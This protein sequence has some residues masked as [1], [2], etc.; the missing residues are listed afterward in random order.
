MNSL[1]FLSVT[2]YLSPLSPFINPSIT[3]GAG[4][5]N[6]RWLSGG[7]SK[8]CRLHTFS[9]RAPASAGIASPAGF[10][11]LGKENAGSGARRR[12]RAAA[13]FAA[14][15][16]AEGASHLPRAGGRGSRTAPG[17]TWAGRCG[18]APGRRKREAR[19][20]HEVCGSRARARAATCAGR[21]GLR[22]GAL[23]GA[24]RRR[25]CAFESANSVARQPA[26]R[27]GPARRNHPWRNCGSEPRADN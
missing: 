18:G 10:G 24:R 2:L 3:K 13:P 12:T 19:R 25:R 21:A 7:D 26:R 27:L 11:G 23:L 8:G 17:C 15:Q 22:S 14:A 6:S 9:F 5:A 20:P 4:L 1:P 16:R